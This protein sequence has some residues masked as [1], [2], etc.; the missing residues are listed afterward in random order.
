MRR[1]ANN[2]RW[3]LAALPLPLLLWATTAEA[4]ETMRIAIAQVRD[5]ISLAGPE[6][7]VTDPAAG[8][9][10]QRNGPVL[11]APTDQGISV[12]GRV[13]AATRLLVQSRGAITVRGLVLERE[14]EVFRELKAGRPELVIVH[15]VPIEAY[16]AATV[17]SEMPSSFPPEALKAQAVVTR[18][19]AVY[20]K[21][22]APERPYHM[23]AGVI[24]QV[25]GGTQRISEPA[26]T[27]ALATQG[28]VLTFRRQPVRAYFHSCCA[29]HTESAREGWGQAL[30]YLPGVECGADGDCPAQHFTARIPLARLARALQ[31]T[32]VKLKRIDDV[33]IVDRTATGRVARLAI[34]SDRGRVEISGEDLRR[35]IGYDVVKSRLFD[36]RIEGDQLVVTGRG[37]GHGVGLCQWG[38]RGMAQ[39]QK[40]YQEI[41]V[42]YFP[43]TKIMKMY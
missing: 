29:G 1:G 41:L 32:R 35:L 30:P 31:V 38:A 19:F 33:T 5:E 11:L 17:S 21:F 9:V 2:L 10:V 20:R 4:E 23:E 34:E 15:T 28:E 16:V 8:E 39:E 26:R 13:V 42:H 36:L 43:H 40:G 7:L 18:T 22:S 14:V 3:A 37:S 6:L 25:F 27:A 12:N 24:D